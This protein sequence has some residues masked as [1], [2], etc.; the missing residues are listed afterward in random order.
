MALTELREKPARE[1][2]PKVA[3]YMRKFWKSCAELLD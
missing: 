2:R 3:G 1:N